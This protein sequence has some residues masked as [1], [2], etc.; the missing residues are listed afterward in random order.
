MLDLDL[1]GVS[2]NGGDLSP[3]EYDLTVAKAEV[4]DT[5]SG[6]GQ[7]INVQFQNE[8][9]QR[10]YHM[11]NIK[12]ANPEA[13]KIGLG[14]LKTFLKMAGLDSTKLTDVTTLEGAL[15][16]AKITEK[17]DSNGVLRSRIS[18]FKKPTGGSTLNGAP[19]PTTPF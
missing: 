12:N 14:Q 8:S 10:I 15:V 1:V 18:S 9:G 6:T 7:Y 19:T 11:F 4:K 13:V 3:G 5:K 17:E 16:R 2:E